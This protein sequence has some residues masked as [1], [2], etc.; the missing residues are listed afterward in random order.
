MSDTTRDRLSEDTSGGE[1]NGDFFDRLRKHARADRER[2]ALVEDS[3]ETT[4]RELL[5]AAEGLASRLPREQAIAIDAP[6]GRAWVVALLATWHARSVAVPLAMAHPEPE[7]EHV[8]VDAGVAGGSRLVLATSE[9]ASRLEG[10][11]ARH[12]LR[13]VDP[14]G[15]FEDVEIDAEID[16]RFQG[17]GSNDDAPALLIYTSGTTGRPKGVP[18][19]HGNL[20]AQV[21]GMSEAWAWSAEDRIVEV[22]PLHHVHGIVNVVAT[23]LWNGASIRILPRFDAERTWRAFVDDEPTLFMAVPTIYNRLLDAWDA[24]SESTR[25]EWSEAASRLRLFVSGSAALPVPVLERWRE[26]TGHTLLERYGMSE[27]G[28]GLGNPL[29]GERLP[30]TVGRPFPGVETRIVD[31]AGD[32]VAEGE[33]GEL[34]VRGP[35][36]FPGYWNRPEATAEAFRDDAEGR[37]WFRTGDVAVRENGVY[38]LL[39][40]SSVDILKTGGEK[41]SALEVEAVLR[42]HPAVRDVAVVGVP[43]PRWGQRV[44]AAVE[45]TGESGSDFDPESLRAWA[46]ERLA[47]Y[48]VPRDVVCV[49]ELPRNALGKVQKPRM[50][51]LLEDGSA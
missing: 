26:I 33:P 2:V 4:Y 9:Q 31:A 51:E 25:R 47:A 32:R 38:R 46:K 48:K 12:D 37:T 13:R 16:T 34:E 39:G 1:S 11:A 44:V 49:D 45:I 41:V 27:I 15:D 5:R 35:S 30:G 36:V 19:T 29:D 20:R 18:L 7:L 21:R 23:A 28:M 6:P 10:L 40:R 24:A 8:L 22:L 14:A 42:A 17:D 50:V 3:G 43:D